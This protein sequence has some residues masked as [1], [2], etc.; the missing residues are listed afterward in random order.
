M[1]SINFENHTSRIAIQLKSENQYSPRHRDRVKCRTIFEAVKEWESTLP[2][3]AQ[4]KIAQLVA[5]EW[6]KVGGRG[7]TVNK[8][9]LY[10]YLEN[11]NGSERYTGY[12]M[13]LAPAITA[14]MPLEIAKKYGW[15]MDE[16]T[17]AELVA[18]A[19][20]VCTEAQQAKLLGAPLQKLERKVCE[21]AI[22][23]FNLLP[24]DV[25]GPL[26]ASISAVAPQCF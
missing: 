17:D 20:T 6:A 15:R 23:L 9:N 18:S 21:A 24:A 5:E 4:G 2:G 12:V 3:Q 19:M 22:R 1:Q 11:E 14:A 26:L 7:I 13:A 16:K 25:A 10:R 8:Q